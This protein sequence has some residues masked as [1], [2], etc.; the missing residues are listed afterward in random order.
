[1]LFNQLLRIGNVS[2]PIRIRLS[3]F[4]ASPAPDLNTESMGKVNNWK[5]L[6]VHKRTTGRLVKHL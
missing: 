1:V 6:S 2:M 4:D 5:I 3:V